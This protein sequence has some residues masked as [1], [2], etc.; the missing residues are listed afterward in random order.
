MSV[1]LQKQIIYK[2]LFFACIAVPYLDTYE[3]TLAIWLTTVLATL[4]NSY[5]VTV[6]KM[7]ASFMAILII[8]LIVGLFRETHLYEFIKDIT[9]LLKPIVGL[10]AGYQLCKDYLKNP[11]ELVVY[12]GLLIAILHLLIIVYAVFVMRVPNMPRLRE[13]SGYFSDFEVYAIIV[14]LFRKDFRL[15]ISHELFFIGVVLLSISIFFYFARTNFI[16][17][18]LLFMAL[19]GYF[20]LNK[21]AVRVLIATV[22]FAV[23][24]YGAIYYYNPQRSVHGLEALLYKIKNAP[25]EPFKTKIN[26]DNWKDFNDNYRSYETI[27]TLRQVPQA[28]TEAVI[29]GKGAGSSIDL[30]KK[31]WLQ[32]SYMRYIPFMHNGF[33]TVFLKSGIIGILVLLYS[34]S[35]FF[36]NKKNNDPLIQTLNYLIL[37]TGIYMILS[38]WVFLGF[39][40]SADTKSIVVGFMIAYREVLIR[41]Q[42]QEEDIP[43]VTA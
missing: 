29:F 34:I 6:I 9:Y 15:K 39:Y 27:L 8:A 3:A 16:Q 42:K 35:L 41:R 36:R 11:M 14:L 37:G 43:L 2:I 1:V 10:L 38:Y 4:R 13:E 28:G 23:S 31:V 33:M 22:I 19:K 12:T 26:V 18:G 5:S 7:L 24:A 20:V 30:H 21:R 32:T 25:I 17:F 40:F